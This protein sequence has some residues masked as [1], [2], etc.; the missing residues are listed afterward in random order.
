MSCHSYVRKKKKKELAKL[1]LCF[2]IHCMH[3][4]KHLAFVKFLLYGMRW[5]MFFLSVWFVTDD[6]NSFHSY[7]SN[8]YQSAIHCP[9]LSSAALSVLFGDIHRSACTICLWNLLHVCL[10]HQPFPMQRLVF[11]DEQNDEKILLNDVEGS[12][13]ELPFYPTFA[14]QNFTVK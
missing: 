12:L 11:M 7:V 14:I 9:F 13:S 10:S 5:W 6:Y 3:L 1:I 8:F 2:I 4:N